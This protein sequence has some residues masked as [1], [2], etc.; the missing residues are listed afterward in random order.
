[1]KNVYNNLFPPRPG[2]TGPF[3]I[4]LCLT[5]DNLT[6]QG[7]AAGWE[8]VNWA[9]Q[10]LCPSLF[11]TLSLLDRPIPAGRTQIVILLRWFYTRWFYPS[12]E[13]NSWWER[14]NEK[15]HVLFSIR[16]DPNCY[17]TRMILH[18]MILFTKGEPLG[19]KGLMKNHM[20]YFLLNTI[21]ILYKILLR[22][23]ESCYNPTC[24]N[25]TLST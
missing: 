11:L 10:A 7:K 1:M 25:P 18:H 3:V 16:P 14:V 2:K 9:Y 20:C 24:Y 17:F 21:I 12:R 5:P 4:L 13:P 6:Y 19:G 8:R 23:W 15:S 22:K